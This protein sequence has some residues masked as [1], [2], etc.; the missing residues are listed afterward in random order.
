MEIKEG[1]T[2]LTMHFHQNPPS[3][4]WADNNTT[5]GKCEKW[6]GDKQPSRL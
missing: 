3:L 6:C 1:E 5:E 4:G 2:F